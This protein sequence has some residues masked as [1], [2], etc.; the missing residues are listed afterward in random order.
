MRVPSLDTLRIIQVTKLSAKPHL[1][2][3]IRPIRPI[4]P[5]SPLNEF[6]AFHFAISNVKFP[7]ASKV[8]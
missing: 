3:W 4:R 2:S 6:F 7:R 5:I 1:N 8:D